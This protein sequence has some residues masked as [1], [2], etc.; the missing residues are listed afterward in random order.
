MK[1]FSF[2]IAAYFGGF[3]LLTISGFFSIWYLGFPLL[4]ISGERQKQLSEAIKSLEVSANFG[5]TSIISSLEERRGDIKIITEDQILIR[6]INNSNPAKLNIDLVRVFERLQRA[7]PDRYRQ[8]DLVQPGTH[9]ILSSSDNT[10]TGTRY[11]DISLIRR[12]SQAGANELIEQVLNNGTL[13][14]AILRQV[15]E[16]DSNGQDTGEIIAIAVAYLDPEFALQRI[17]NNGEQGIPTASSA[18]LMDAEGDPLAAYQVKDEDIKSH[19]LHQAVKTG[20]EGAVITQNA[21]GKSQVV[22]TRHIQLGSGNGWT[23]A[24]FKNTEDILSGINKNIRTFSLIALLSTLLGLLIIFL[25]AKKAASPL[26]N[27]TKAS[28]LIGQGAL[29]T[30]VPISNN[31]S[32][33]E[34]AQLSR[35]FNAM[36]SRVEDAQQILEAE[37]QQRTLELKAERDSA[38]RYLYV[39]AIMLIALDANGRISMINKNGAAILEDTVENLI[40]LNW[41]DQFLPAEQRDSIHQV[42]SELMAGNGKFL[43]SYENTIISCKG[44]KR[45]IAWHNVQLHDDAGNITGTLSS[46]E[47]VTERNWI[48]ERHSQI[49]KTAMDAFLVVGRKGKLLE[50]NTKACTM[51][52]YSEREL[53]SL[54]ISEIEACESPEE[55]N[56][57]I[58]KIMREGDDRFESK[59]RTKDGKEFRVEVAAKF[60]PADGNI[61]VFIHDINERKKIEEALINSEYLLSAMFRNSPVGLA[62]GDLNTKTFLD[63]NQRWLE[64]L[65][66]P[67]EEVVG[68]KNEDINLWVDL[69]QRALILGELAVGR[70]TREREVQMYSK[71]REIRSLLFSVDPIQV[72][73]H[74]YTLS[75]ISDITAHKAIEEQIHN[76]AFF[77]PLTNLPNRRLLLDRLNYSMV[78]SARSGLYH[79]LLFLD[80]DQFKTLNDTSGHDVGDRLLIEVASRLQ[81]CVREGDTVSRLGGDEF[82]VILEQLS[83]KENE[84]A[85][86]AGSVAEKIIQK[87]SAPC[88]LGTQTYRGTTSIGITLFYGQDVSIDDLLKR[89]DLAMYQ[90]KAA[91]RNAMRNFD[92]SMQ[93][94]I[95]ARAAMENELCLAIARSEFVLHYQPQIFADGTCNGVEALIRWH[96][97]KRGMV[98]P[99]DFIPL[100][101]ESGLILPIG[102][103]VI[104][105]A[106]SQ[107]A[108]WAD[109]PELSE[110]SIAVNVSAKQFKL[111]GFVDEVGAIVDGYR[112]NPQLLKLEITESVLLEDI[113]DIAT[114][115]TQLKLSGIRFSLDDF[116]TGY[117]SLSYVKRLP[118]DQLKIDQSFVRDIL[119][120]PNDAAICRAIIALGT[121]L[122]LE[123]VAEGVETAAQWEFL[124]NEGC[125]VGQG[126][127]FGKPMPSA[128]FEAWQQ[129]RIAP[130]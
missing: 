24:Y 9:L 49:L 85:M 69:D 115:M 77:D 53:L 124:E 126:Y 78:N 125:T 89:A 130:E 50:V 84:A 75:S 35:A 6:A 128:E 32:A 14:L 26:N 39:A 79:A 55:V 34:I 36:A 110:I 102:S 121:S 83:A 106:C 81:N 112:I 95:S 46:G 60:M 62:L 21:A 33:N 4:G 56:R 18:A 118:L 54:K 15:H 5:R 3:Y 51:L 88:D 113:E 117:S 108:A 72:G 86:Q 10:V 13:T 47:D 16:I 43:T 59:L 90:A 70:G 48:R 38:Q 99:I 101:E 94:D 96:S 65:G 12:A 40:G 80:L 17:L 103:W 129:H 68:R 100:A 122:G 82:V 111:T 93:A 42:F 104:Q 91:G 23:L 25:L 71:S 44:N 29:S 107:L 28:E 74:N 98:P 20:V 31:H 61:Y 127:F 105:E 52:G 64:I 97:S 8:I 11:S 114:K 2:R 87:I 76:L 119:I 7:Y 27:L 37:V 66:Y 57:R 73:Q 58:E 109:K 22:V 1:S 92:P 116:G 41:F 63:V 67:R 45:L 120:D 123:V 30:R 19:Y